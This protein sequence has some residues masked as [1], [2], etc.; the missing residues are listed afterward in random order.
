M[1][2]AV[3]LIPDYSIGTESYSTLPRDYRYSSILISIG[4]RTIAV[5]FLGT[6]DIVSIGTRASSTL[7]MNY[8]YI[9][10]W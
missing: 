8:R 3:T 5:L 10:S 7:P 9:L 6:I 4:T 2:S 1:Y